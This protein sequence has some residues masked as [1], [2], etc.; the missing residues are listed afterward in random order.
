MSNTQIL[1]NSRHQHPVGQ[2]F[3]H[4]GA[5]S[6]G[7]D[8]FRYAYD[9]GSEHIGPLIQCIQAYIATLPESQS[10]PRTLDVLFV[11]HLHND[12]VN[13]ID[14]L[15]SEVRVETVVLPY[16]SDAERLVLL[17]KSL[18]GPFVSASFVQL[19]S[20]PPRWFGDHG[21][22]R[23]ILIKG[24]K[25]HSLKIPSLLEPIFPQD[26]K[27]RIKKLHLED[28]M[29]K[30]AKATKVSDGSKIKVLIM[31]HSNP[32]KIMA[33]DVFML[34]WSFITFVHPEDTKIKSFRKAVKKS[35]GKFPPPQKWLVN[36]VQDSKM[37]LRLLSC[38]EKIRR[39]HNLISLSLYSGPIILS[40][41][42]HTQVWYEP[43]TSWI[44]NP[45]KA[46]EQPENRRCAWLGTGDSNLRARSRR[47]QFMR[48]FEP[49]SDFVDS[50]ALPHHGS[51]KN[52]D[53]EILNLG[54][55]ICVIA[56][57]INNQYGHPSPEVV[58]SIL[59]KRC[60]L[61]RVNQD[62][63]SWWREEVTLSVI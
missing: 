60:I 61:V 11:S 10:K 1:F 19:L 15:L 49:V 14:K 20:N 50:L 54:A 63:N 45:H 28:R 13:G 35:F 39:N 29:F 43:N 25:R 44:M 4:T 62:P 57:G 32:L 40:P 42:F 41:N 16:L 18:E 48:H 34:N 47:S 46:L 55:H 9:C 22:K 24:D 2:G 31:S 51:N 12:H 52:F 58:Q 27:I 23:I 6:L 17:A 56:S 30:N 38:Y 26:A 59:V 53:P 5:L 21:V 8:T 3:F 37:R 7:Q 33:D 36:I